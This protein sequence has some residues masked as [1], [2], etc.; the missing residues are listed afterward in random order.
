MDAYT[1]EIQVPRMDLGLLAT[2]NH[3]ATRT[4]TPRKDRMPVTVDYRED[5]QILEVV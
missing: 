5:K 4:K 3:I 2:N 1:L